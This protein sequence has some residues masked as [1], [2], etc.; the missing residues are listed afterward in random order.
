[1]QWRLGMRPGMVV[2]NSHPGYLNGGQAL[3][4]SPSEN[5]GWRSRS[6][7]APGAGDAAEHVEFDL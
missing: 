2:V 1:M 6:V 5:M 7:R 3:L 4:S